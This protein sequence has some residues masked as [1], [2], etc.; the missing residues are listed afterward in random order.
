MK[1]SLE[2]A[3]VE[4]EERKSNMARVN[5]DV[6]K[7][8]AEIS[9]LKHKLE[10]ERER[11]TKLEQYTRRENV[12]LL[13]VKESNDEDTKQ[14]FQDVL[15]EMG[16]EI[17]GMR[18]HAVHRVGLQRDQRR[19]SLNQSSVRR[20]I[21]ARSVCREDK[22]YVWQNRHKIKDSEK[23]KEAFFL[24]DLAKEQTQEEYVLRQ[25]YRKAMEKYELNVEIK[26]IS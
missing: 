21:I 25:A 3:W 11:N 8:K 17:T 20:H 2:E 14:V 13:N 26:I 7:L 24:P 16:I 12:R 22:D 5:E 15:T 23:F 9:N 6:V 4:V 1:V 18:F 10:Q 19:R